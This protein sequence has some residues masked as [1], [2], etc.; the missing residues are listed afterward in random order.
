IIPTYS[1]LLSATIYDKEIQRQTLGNDGTT[2]P[3][4]DLII[5]DY[6]TLGEI[7][8]RG[9]AQVT[10][11]Q[12]EFDFVVPRD[13]AIPVGNGRVSFYSEDNL[14]LTDQTGFSEIIQV[15]GIN[16]DA[17]EDNTPPTIRLHMNDE[18]FVSGGITNESPFVLAFLEDE[19][20][21]NTAS[22]IGHDIEVILDGDE[23]NPFILNDYYETEVNNYRRGTVRYQL[24]D[25][26]PGFHT[27]SLKAW[28]VY[29]NSSVQEIRFEVFDEDQDLKITNV[30]NYP[31]PF[32]DYTE[33]WFSH[34][35]STELDILV[36]VYTISGKLV[37]TLQGKANSGSDI[38]DSS[39][40]SR[41]IVWNGLD[42][43]GD[44][45]G[46]GVYVYKLTVKSAVTNKQVSKFEKLV[47][48]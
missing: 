12:F 42:D 24:R 20:G 34:N 23:Q 3:I 48:L 35:S 1:G 15:G 4:G 32:V 27:L 7:L 43:F 44:K 2:N 6:T 25:L 14:L 18:S 26:E 11:G 21:I 9:Q 37:K 39:S 46:K 28:D 13:I 36:Q 33:F 10:G 5:M 47:I 17:P 41:D 30:L 45:I 31:N 19:N 8:F 29:N 16:S 40:I 22:G 38:K